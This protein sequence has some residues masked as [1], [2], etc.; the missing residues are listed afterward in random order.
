MNNISAVSLNNT[1]N[2]NFLCA[3]QRAHNLSNFQIK[4]VLELC[5]GPSLK[6]LEQAYNHQRIEVTGN[7]IDIRWKHYYPKGKWIIGDALKIDYAG[8]DAIVFAPPLSKGCTGKREDS[9]TIFQVCPS[10]YSFVERVA[11]ESNQKLAVLTLPGRSLATRL[12]RTEYFKLIDFIQRNDF[13]ID[14]FELKN[15]V[16]K[17]IDLII[18]RN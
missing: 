9:L 10:Y 2:T 3:Q 15:K 14:S 7:D 13:N 5:V 1:A 8:F 12:D 18:W 6:T 11:N 16:I 17:Y 4:S